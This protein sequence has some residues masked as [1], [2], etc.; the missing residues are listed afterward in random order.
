MTLGGA[1]RRRAA[2]IVAN[3]QRVLDEAFAANPERFVNNPPIVDGLP[4]ESWINPPEDKTR[5]EV[6]LH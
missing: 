6:Q 1:F 2:V 4:D 3:Q 5:S